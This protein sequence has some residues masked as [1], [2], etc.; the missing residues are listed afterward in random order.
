MN[1]CLLR[2]PLTH[3]AKATGHFLSEV[4]TPECSPSSWC[5]GR[6]PHRVGVQPSSICLCCTSRGLHPSGG[7]PVSS[8][9]STLVPGSSGLYFLLHIFISSCLILIY[10][11]S[12]TTLESTFH[13]ASPFTLLPKVQPIIYFI[14]VA[15]LL[16][17][18]NSVFL[19]YAAYYCLLKYWPQSFSVIFGTL[20][21][22]ELLAFKVFSFLFTS[23]QNFTNV[24]TSDWIQVY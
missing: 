18:K 4:L 22:Q 5:F 20:W 12:P 8:P 2:K 17:I 3:L 9:C 21:V 15:L 16:F 24:I 10:A 14:V 13:S 19:S 11:D 7:S 1:W 6:I 23:Q